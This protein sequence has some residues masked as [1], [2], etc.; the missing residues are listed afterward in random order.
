VL[1]LFVC[2]LSSVLQADDLAAL[3]RKEKE[4]RAKIAKPAKVLTQG[5]AKETTGSVTVPL[6][7]SSEGT[8]TSSREGESREAESPEVRKSAWKARAD[9]ARA[10]VAAAEEKLVA[11][12]R[13]FATFQADLAPLSA[14]EAQDPMRLQNRATR[15]EELKKAVL[16]QKAAFAEAKKAISTLEDEARKKGVPPGWLR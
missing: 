14:A 6:A 7:I 4:R 3:A 8:A 2:L 13:E 12:E 11:L 10:E 16:T 1:V 5:D 15:L 9:H